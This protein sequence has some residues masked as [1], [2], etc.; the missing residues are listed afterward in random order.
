MSVNEVTK[1]EIQCVT[2]MFKQI[3]KTVRIIIPETS[4]ILTKEYLK[5]IVVKLLQ[6]LYK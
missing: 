2:D 3:F 5:Q 4:D 1:I 6:E